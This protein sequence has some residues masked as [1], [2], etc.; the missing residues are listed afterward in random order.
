MASLQLGRNQTKL[1]S[2]L[3]KRGTRIPCER[4]PGKAVDPG[5]FDASRQRERG[6]YAFVFGYPDRAATLAP[7]RRM[8]QKRERLVEEE[9]VFHA[10]VPHLGEQ[11]RL[12][13]FFLDVED[14]QGM[15]IVLDP[16]SEVFT[17]REWIVR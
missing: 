8:D 6:L 10:T 9:E 12:E 4:K 17:M 14:Q 11:P 1:E 5:P 2:D 7:L 15:A 13:A 3:E 16:V